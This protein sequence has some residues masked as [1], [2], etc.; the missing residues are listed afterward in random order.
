MSDIEGLLDR[1]R[2]QMDLDGEIEEEVLAEIRDHL[3]EAV[4]DARAEGLDEAGALARA[5]ARFG[6]EEEVGR[7]LQAAH[8]G[9]GTA[10]AVVA[11]ALPVVCALVLRWLA[12]APDGTALGWPQ[13]LSRPAFWIVALAALLIPLLRFERWR[14]ALA[15]WV[16]FWALTVV[17]VTLPAL[18]W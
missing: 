9:W 8:A 11:A 5:S 6:L 12:F 15:T 10:D 2:D 4:A 3:E 7:E 1:I 14:Y 18:R 16:F 13:L 17:F